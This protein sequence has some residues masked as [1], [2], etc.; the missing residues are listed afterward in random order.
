M[1]KW[2]CVCNLKRMVTNVDILWG[3][4]FLIRH[5]GQPWASSQL[6]QVET[7]RSSSQAIPKVSAAALIFRMG[8]PVTSE[9]T[10]SCVFSVCHVR[11]GICLQIH[12]ASAL[13]IW[14]Y[15]LMWHPWAFV[16]VF[17][18][19]LC[20]LSCNVFPDHKELYS[21]VST[22]TSSLSSYFTKG[23]LGLRFWIPSLT[24][25]V[26]TISNLISTKCLVLKA[27][28][29]SLNITCSVGME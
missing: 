17:P 15:M 1:A 28:G 22:I 11:L 4:L 2:S 24:L 5:L 27:R 12:P 16:T 13:V 21:S 3:Y 25:N 19:P 23:L 7:P 9:P 14:G 29:F 10:G 6:L 26:F 8:V 18:N 20:S